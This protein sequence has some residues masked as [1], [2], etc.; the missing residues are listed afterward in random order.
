MLTERRINPNARPELPFPQDFIVNYMHPNFLCPF[1]PQDVE[2][3]RKL[4]ILIENFP[5]HEYF[6]IETRNLQNLI[7]IHC[8]AV[9]P[10]IGAPDGHVYY[11]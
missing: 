9:Q 6:Y 2:V 10:S 7:F 11:Q 3:C 8:R 1:S 5:G 4:N